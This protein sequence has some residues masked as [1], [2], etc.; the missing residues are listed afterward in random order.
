MGY[1]S[2]DMGCDRTAEA[3][4][5]GGKIGVEGS[6]EIARQANRSSTALAQPSI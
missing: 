4:S 6:R 3:A 2:N 1:E 5:R